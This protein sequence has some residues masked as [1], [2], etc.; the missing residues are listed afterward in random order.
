MQFDR[1]RLWSDIAYGHEYLGQSDIQG[2]V[3][4]P[5]YQHSQQVQW[6]MRY[7]FINS[8]KDRGLR[9]GRY[10]NKIGEGRG[11]QYQELYAGINTKLYGD[12]F[13]LHLAGQY[14]QMQDKAGDEG[15]YEGWSLT[16]ALRS[17]W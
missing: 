11:D 2:F 14:T 4:M 5:I 6:L 10:E 8:D 13:K 12:K 15:A 9:L 7:T 16:R 3:L 17:Y 1:I